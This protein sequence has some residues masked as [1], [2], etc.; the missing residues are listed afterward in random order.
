VDGSIGFS[1]SVPAR[2]ADVQKD[3]RRAVL[4]SDNTLGQQL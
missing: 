4:L 1:I 2:H 3:R